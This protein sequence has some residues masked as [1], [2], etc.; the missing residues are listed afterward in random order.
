MV[1]V[2]EMNQALMRT[3]IITYQNLE[4]ETWLM[5]IITI[6]GHLML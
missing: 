5:V 2:V 3:M 1:E 4:K 6:Q